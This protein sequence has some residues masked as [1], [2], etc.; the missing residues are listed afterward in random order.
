MEWRTAAGGTGAGSATG[1]TRLRPPLPALAEIGGGRGT[2]PVVPFALRPEFG[3]R[4]EYC[5][6]PRAELGCDRGVSC[7]C[8]FSGYDGGSGKSQTKSVCENLHVEWPAMCC[9][10]PNL[11]YRPIGPHRC[12]V[13]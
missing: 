13:L 7:R 6:L 5:F 9:A 10:A 2:S 8:K 11:P 12:C 4:A 1:V 3:G